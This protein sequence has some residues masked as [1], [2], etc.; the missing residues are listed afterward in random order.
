MTVEIDKLK[1]LAL[2]ATQGPWL[3]RYDPGNPKGV[4]HGVKLAGEFGAWVCDCLDNADQRTEAG[5]AGERNAAYIAAACPTVVFKLIAEVE[6]LRAAT[7]PAPV[8]AQAGTLRFKDHN[9]RQLVNDLRDIA[10]TF[11]AAQQL[12]SRIQDAI[13]RFLA[14]RC[15]GNA[16]TDEAKDAARFRQAIAHEDSAELLYAATLNHAPD[17]DAIRREFDAWHIKAGQVGK[18]RG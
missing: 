18:E 10:L 1:A 13:A 14:T 4:Q 7:Q 11:H 3:H 9:I 12:R 16:L 17:A 2:A 15:A 8:P 5:I 6:R